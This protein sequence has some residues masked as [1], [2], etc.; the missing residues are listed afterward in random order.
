MPN[1]T[2]PVSATRLLNVAFCG[3]FII[4]ASLSG[5]AHVQLRHNAV[6]QA[7]AVG[8]FEQQEVMD[9]LAMFVNNINS[10]PHFSFPNQTATSVT[11][12]DSAGMT[13]AWSRPVTSGA[14]V[15]SGAF[16]TP[17]KFADFLFGTLGLNFN[18]QRQ[19]QEGFTI[20][21]IN[22]P[23]KLELMRCAYQQAVASCGCGTMSKNCP[24]CQAKFNSFYT[25]DPE[26]KISE[27]GGGG[28]TSEC[29]K[30]K[31]WFH[32]GCKGDVPKHCDCLWVGHYCGTYVW[33]DAA[34]RDELTKLTLAILDYAL[35]SPPTKRNKEVVYYVDELG[36]PTT[37]KDAVGKVTAQ[38]AISE[39]NEGLLATTP[40]EEFRI[41]QIL[42]GELQVLQKRL[43]E[44]RDP[45]ERVA[46]L[47]QQAVL[48]RK[49]EFVKQQIK[50]GG[51]K[52][53]YYPGSA[54]PIAPFSVLPLLQLQQNTLTPQP[55]T[56]PPQQIIP[57]Q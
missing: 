41:Q 33:V 49:L 4:L 13:P 2:M 56:P 17:P 53:Q 25:G 57:P 35:N 51:L 27:Q 21:P 12:Q 7:A 36:L 15:V 30:G 38:V 28:I 39:R 23:H 3:C 46:L 8:E 6:N 37:Q 16:K 1:E 52:E 11:D 20:T 42:E 32:V 47:N 19:S 5:C 9:N 43:T 18:A 14:S 44:V 24:D 22:D 54:E 45:N 29:L 40:Q 55:L 10:F 31:C 48:E 50:E 34:G 26:G